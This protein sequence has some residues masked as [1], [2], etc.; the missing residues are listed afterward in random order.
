MYQRL[1]D[2]LE[3]ARVRYGEPRQPPCTDDRLEQ[4]RQRMREELGAELPDE[5]AAFLRD[6]DGMNH[7]GLFIYA[8]GTA[9]VVGARDATIQ[10]I[11]EANLGWRDVEQMVSYLVF[12]E[13]NMDVYVLHVPTGAY[14]VIDRVPGN[15]IETHPSFDQLLAAAL[16]AHL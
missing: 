15:L 1:L 10:G 3:A 2:E 16:R 6:Q 7:N 13:G 9:P 12:G 11:V 4:L 5:Y 14:Q 8:S